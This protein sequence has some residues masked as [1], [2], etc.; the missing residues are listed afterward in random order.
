MGRSWPYAPGQRQP[1]ES[2]A[3]RREEQVQVQHTEDALLGGGRS[4]GK[5]K[6]KTLVRCSERSGSD[7]RLTAIVYT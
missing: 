6:A 3:A 4:A 7:S 2:R 1:S 5:G